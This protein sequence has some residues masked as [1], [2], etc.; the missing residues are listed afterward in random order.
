MACVEVTEL[1]PTEL[2]LPR[3]TIARLRCESTVLHKQ[4]LAASHGS[5]TDRMNATRVQE[6]T[7]ESA[8]HAAVDERL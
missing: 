8:Q 6:W 4:T 1:A 3:L 5:P 7:Q 2:Q